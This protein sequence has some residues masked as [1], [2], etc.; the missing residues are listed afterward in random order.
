VS[1]TTMSRDASPFNLPC[2]HLVPM[3]WRAMVADLLVVL[4][5]PCCYMFLTCSYLSRFLA[6]SKYSGSRSMPIKP[7][8]RF[9]AAK[10]VEPDLSTELSAKDS[11]TT[12]LSELCITIVIICFL[13]AAC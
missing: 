12:K 11:S 4:E 1:P 9:L 6:M 7:I 2:S 13:Y 10:P 8:P 5:R 3:D